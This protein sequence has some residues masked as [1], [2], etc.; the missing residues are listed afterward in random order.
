MASVRATTAYRLAGAGIQ[1]QAKVKASITHY[2]AGVFGVTRRFV[3][4]Y[5]PVEVSYSA[6]SRQYTEI[7]RPGDWPLIDSVG[8]QLMK[9]Q[10]EFRVAD[11]A[12]N[13]LLSIEDRLDTLRL[14]ALFPGPCQVSNMDGYLSRPIA[15]TIT[16]EGLKLAFFRI[17]DLGIT[18]KR[19]DRD[20]RATQADVQMT[21]SE[22]RNPYIAA[23]A[24]PPIDYSDTPTRRS[25]GTTATGG[26]PNAGNGGG[27]RKTFFD[28]AES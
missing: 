2:G 21:L 18:V 7:A 3:F 13:G 19:R 11:P 6:L 28:V 27:P 1:T 26:A 14:M 20:N 15:P 12:S 9:V 10:L 16:Y 8:P 17:T 23:I 22:D 4:P 5:A 25:A 24:L